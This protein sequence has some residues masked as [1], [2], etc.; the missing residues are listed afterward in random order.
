MLHDYDPLDVYNCAR[1]GTDI[2]HGKCECSDFA[3]ASGVRRGDPDRVFLIGYSDLHLSH[4]PKSITILRPLLRVGEVRVDGQR[5]P[6]F[7]P[8]V[9]EGIRVATYSRQSNE[10]SLRYSA[11][12]GDEDEG[13]EASD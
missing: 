3:N 4:E 6:I 7:S 9:G 5:V 1:C 2:V 10:F 13:R 12:A 11:T 8:A